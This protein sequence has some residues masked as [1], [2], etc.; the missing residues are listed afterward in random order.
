MHVRALI[1]RGAVSLDAAKCLAGWKVCADRQAILRSVSRTILERWRGVA[2]A[3]VVSE[4][5]AWM[6]ERK[7]GLREEKALA[8]ARRKR[9]QHGLQ[10]WRAWAAPFIKMRAEALSLAKQWK[11]ELVVD[12]FR[13][14]SFGL[15]ARMSEKP[16]PCPSP[17]FVWCPVSCVMSDVTLTFALCIAYCVCFSESACVHRVASCYENNRATT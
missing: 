1:S 9:L 14:T 2:L 12:A 8:I 16:V 15:E 17:L 7:V 4:W 13:Q 11:M 10:R 6:Q 3:D 5:R